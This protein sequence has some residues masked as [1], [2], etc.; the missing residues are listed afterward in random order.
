MHISATRHEDTQLQNSKQQQ[1][2]MTA[3]EN[4]QQQPSNTNNTGLPK[5]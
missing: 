4:K 5:S 3:K 1:P 2:Q